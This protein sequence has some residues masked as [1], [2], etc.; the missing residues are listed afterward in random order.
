MNGEGAAADT[1]HREAPPAEA[2]HILVVDDDD[3]LRALLG[4]YLRDNGYLVSTASTA[5]EARAKL[6][7]MTFD[8]IVLDVMMPGE[9]GVEFTRG[10]RRSDT[11]PVL[12]LTAMTEPED[13]IAGLESGADDYLTKPF[14][15]RELLLRVA[16]ILR[17]TAAAPPAT[18]ETCIVM[19]EVR[20]FPA[21]DQLL[22]GD[23]PV[24]LTTAEADLLRVFAANP[25]EMMSR[26]ALSERLGGGASR[27]AIDVQ[28][29]RLRRKIEPD[30]QNPR[31]LQTV[32]GRG[33]VLRAD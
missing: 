19:G 29:A 33:Y 30:P 14:E 21:R 6:D 1:A 4:R 26:H 18:P 24:R 10:L 9:S 2:K 5:A 16:T 12:L 17:R 11:V 3:R 8:L 20:Y 7:G 13:R 15:P 25:G 27:R 32:W 31:Y 22:R 23:E 28:I